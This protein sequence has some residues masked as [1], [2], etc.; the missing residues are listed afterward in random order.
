MQQM[1]TSADPYQMR[2][3]KLTVREMLDGARVSLDGD[4]TLPLSAKATLTASLASVYGNLGE[5]PIGLEVLQ[6]KDPALDQLPEDSLPKLRLHFQR[7]VALKNTGEVEAARAELSQVLRLPRSSGALQELRVDALIL[8]MIMSAEDGQAELSL[9]QI[10]VLLPEIAE[11]LGP[12]HIKSFEVEQARLSV[13]FLLRRFVEARAAGAALIPRMSQALGA[14]HPVKLITQ[15]D[16]S[17]ILEQTGDGPGGE[18]VLRSAIADAERI[19]GPRHPTTLSF[20]KTLGGNLWMQKRYEEAYGILTETISAMQETL[21][22]A[23]SSALDAMNNQALVL[24]DMGRVEDSARMYQQII[25]IYQKHQIA[26]TA[27][28]LTKYNNLAYLYLNQKKY[29]EAEA[30][31]AEVVQRAG[32]SIGETH[33]DYWEYVGNWGLAEKKLE[34]F[35]AARYH[36]EAA[37]TKLS[38]MAGIESI[39]AQ[40]LAKR[41]KILYTER[42]L[43]AEAEAISAK[44]IPDPK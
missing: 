43:K 44:I 38:V 4:K 9:Q 13:Y 12:E 8:Q 2:G 1:L 27:D 31:W 22:E 41:L 28:V 24:E 42:G 25:A 36:Y 17:L 10:N 21:G 39:T 19:Y 5:Y 33:P 40:T 14:G 37:F 30:L 15:R 20:R 3:P 7:A 18:Q 26:D 35:E 6:K 32:K 16:Y 23:N 34:R 29:A 11:T